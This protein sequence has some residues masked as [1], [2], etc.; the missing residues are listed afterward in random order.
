MV[1]EAGHE[2][3]GES[4]NEQRN[5]FLLSLDIFSRNLQSS[6]RSLSGGLELKKPDERIE[7]EGAN[8]MSDSALVIKSMNLLHDDA[9][10][11]GK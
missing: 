9:N 3:W 8:A 6:I 5:E 1:S 11:T 4:S 2:V 10:I 7:R